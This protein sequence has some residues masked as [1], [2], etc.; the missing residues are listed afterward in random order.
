MRASSYAAGGVNEGQVAPDTVTLLARPSAASLD[1]CAEVA[2]PGVGT[3][4]AAIAAWILAHPGLD[5]TPRPDITLDGLRA[6]VLDLAVRDDWTETCDAKNPFVAAPVLIGDYHWAL[7]KG[8]RMRIILVDLPA[9][10]TVAISI[11]PEDP[12]TFDS[13]VA[14][15]MPIV[16]SL[17]FK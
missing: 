3:N 14:E 7:G 11:D 10:T 16:E 4:R 5:V 8:D 6:S 17:D 9:G 13:L 2:E 12:A 1:N 15:T